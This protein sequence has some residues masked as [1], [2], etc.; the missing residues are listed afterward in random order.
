MCHPWHDIELG[1][2]VPNEFPVVIEIPEGSRVKYEI[3][4]LTGFLKV[5]RILHSA[6]HYPANYGFIP[7]S[8]CEDQDPLDVLVLGQFPVHPL[9]LMTVK[10]IGVIKMTDQ[11][12][13]DDKIIA[14]HVDD[15]E[16]VIYNSVHELPPYQLKKIK[17]FFETYKILEKGK[18]FIENCLDQVQ[19]YPIIQEAILLYREHVKN[20]NYYASVRGLKNH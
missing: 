20:F 2:Q 19:A 1:K 3:D 5:D 13:V 7:R 6:V 11:G 8:Y 9:T 12:E 14:V 15:P 16:Y 10:P 18:V 17:N 4:K